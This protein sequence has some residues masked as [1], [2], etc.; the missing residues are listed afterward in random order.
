MYTFSI[1]LAPNDKVHDVLN[2]IK[3]AVYV[4]NNFNNETILFHKSKVSELSAGNG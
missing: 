1:R 4:H 3:A 2:T